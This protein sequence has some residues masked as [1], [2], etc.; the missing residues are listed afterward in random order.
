MTS[1]IFTTSVLESRRRSWKFSDEKVRS[2]FWS[3]HSHFHIIAQPVVEFEIGKIIVYNISVLVYL[4][5]DVM[6]A[7]KT[8]ETTFHLPKYYYKRREFYE[9]GSISGIFDSYTGENIRSLYHVLHIMAQY[10]IP[11]RH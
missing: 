10:L 8:V 4:E 6:Q 5:T 11:P 3:H 7:A 2:Q 1:K 9:P